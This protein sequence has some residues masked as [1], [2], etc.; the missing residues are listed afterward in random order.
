MNPPTKPL[1]NATK[2]ETIAYLGRA[3]IAKHG[4]KGV[5]YRHTNHANSDGESKVLIFESH[6]QAAKWINPLGP[7]A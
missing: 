3:T 1:W 6:R 7:A 4:A 5:R 2:T